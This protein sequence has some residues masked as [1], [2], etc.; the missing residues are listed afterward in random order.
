[1]PTNPT[2]LLTGDEFRGFAKSKVMIVLWVLM[3]GIALVGFLL[4][5]HRARLELGPGHSISA[6]QYMGFLESGI[7]GA[8]ASVLVA[9]EIVSDRSRN[10]YQ[11]FVIR[12]IR[13]ESL[14][15]AKF[16][17]ISVLV[18]IAA[19]ISMSIGFIFDA[20]EGRPIDADELLQ[21]GKAIL[22]TAQGVGL[23]CAG[24]VLF[25]VL[26]KDSILVAVVLVLQIGQNFIFIPQIP[27]FFGV[28]QHQFWL[29]TAITFAFL[30]AVMWIAGIAFRRSQF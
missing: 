17:A 7:A 26:A 2:L 15:W 16:I 29:W 10:V 21:S 18:I 8:I 3:P 23:A 12:P 22:A 11:L 13:P 1:M 20:T 25:G 5:R 14:L 4:L 24:G 6:K 30:F 9:V 27:A 19:T 28:M